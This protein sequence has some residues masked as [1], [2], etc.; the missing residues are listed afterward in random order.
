MKRELCLI[1]LSLFVP[2]RPPRVYTRNPRPWRQKVENGREWSR[3]APG[4][5][6]TARV[7]PQSPSTAS[8]SLRWTGME[9]GTRPEKT[10]GELQIPCSSV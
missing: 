5:P 6:S 10:A 8:K 9:L 1:H 2:S 4:F 3:N 7:Y